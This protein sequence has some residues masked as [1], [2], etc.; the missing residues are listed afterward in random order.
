MSSSLYWEVV[1]PNGGQRMSDGAKFILRR[2]FGDP[3]K[4]IIAPDRADFLRGIEAAT[5]DEK[6]RGELS[7]I[8]RALD[9]GETIKIEERW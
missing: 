1:R 4:V 3:V 6:V 8:I 7:D 2:A 9:A 5:D